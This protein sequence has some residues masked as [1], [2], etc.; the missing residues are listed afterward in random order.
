LDRCSTID[1]ETKEYCEMIADAEME[2]YQ[3]DVDTYVEM[4]GKD[5]LEAQKKT[6][7]KRLKSVSADTDADMKSTH[8]SGTS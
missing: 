2:Q 5:A 4:Y 3:I 1:V 6:H 7:N 8:D